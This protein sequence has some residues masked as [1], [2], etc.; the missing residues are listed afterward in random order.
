MSAVSKIAKNTSILLLSQVISYI[1][2]FFYTIYTARYLGTAGFGILSTAL[3]LGALLSIFT[4]LGLS[5]LTTREVSR[6]KSLAN[7]YIG[8]T[9]ALKI[10][11]S[12]LSLIHISEPTRP[13]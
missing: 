7:K 6:E 10:A 12:T 3:A 2:A 4:E 1:L 5:T 9:I 8:N 11:L 13:Y